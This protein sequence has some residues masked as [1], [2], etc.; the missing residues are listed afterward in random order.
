MDIS[1]LQNFQIFC[2]FLVSKF[3]EN[4]MS[5]NICKHFYATLYYPISIKKKYKHLMPHF[6]WLTGD[7][8]DGPTDISCNSPLSRK[9]GALFANIDKQKKWKLLPRRHFIKNIETK[10]LKQ[11]HCNGSIAKWR[12]SFLSSFP[13]YLYFVRMRSV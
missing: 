7:K 4:G 5:L 2:N 13:S 11:S 3:Y 1:A 6:H 10:L 8:M 12:R 9:T